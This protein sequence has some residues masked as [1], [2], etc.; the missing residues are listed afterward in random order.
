[1][2]R[3][4]QR[5]QRS[6]SLILLSRPLGDGRGLSSSCA[7][8]LSLLVPCL[9]FEAPR[10]ETHCQSCGICIQHKPQSCGKVMQQAGFMQHMCIYQKLQEPGRSTLPLRLRPLSVTAATRRRGGEGRK[11]GVGMRDGFYNDKWGLELTT[12]PIYN[13]L[14]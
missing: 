8:R 2:R 10:R 1:M 5:V 13:S 6:V 12:V 9:R 4:M 3:F 14:H 7:P 11:G